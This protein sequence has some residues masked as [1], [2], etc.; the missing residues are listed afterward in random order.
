M[1]VIDM[2]QQEARI[3]AFLSQDKNLIEILKQK[4]KDIFVEMAKKIYNMEITKD[5]PKRKIIK[6]IIYGMSYGMSP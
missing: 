5:D 2:G 4:D 3:N 6:N 1:I